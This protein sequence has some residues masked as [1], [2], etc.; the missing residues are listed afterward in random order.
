MLARARVSD[1]LSTAIPTVKNA[2]TKVLQCDILRFGHRTR[3]AE[4]DEAQKETITSL[5]VSVVAKQYSV[6]MNLN[7]LHCCIV[8]QSY[9]LKNVLWNLLVN[10]SKYEDTALSFN[11]LF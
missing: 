3:T 9:R 5:L 4:E 2:V 11:S 10:C 6:A 8:H 7:G 1:L